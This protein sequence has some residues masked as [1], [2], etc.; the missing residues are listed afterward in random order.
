MEIAR[1]VVE[2]GGTVWLEWPSQC[3]YWRDPQV[4]AF[5][6]EIGLHKAALHG[7]AHGWKDRKGNFMTKPWTI[8]S[9]SGIATSGLER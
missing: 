5:A 7:R 8:A 6:R 9:A 2:A 4:R 3:Q 1:A